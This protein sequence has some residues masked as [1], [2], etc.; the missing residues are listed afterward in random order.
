MGRSWRKRDRE[1]IADEYGGSLAEIEKR[2]GPR[3]RRWRMRRGLSISDTARQAKAQGVACDSSYLSRMERGEVNIPLRT[4]LALC[5]VLRIGPQDV[6]GRDFPTTQS[7][8][9]SLPQR[10]LRLLIFLADKDTRLMGE[11]LYTLLD[12]L[13][14]ATEIVSDQR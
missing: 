1:S 4:M 11:P 3:L 12:G 14:K 7:A 13:L 5:R 6:L 9:D 10:T 2:V 8:L